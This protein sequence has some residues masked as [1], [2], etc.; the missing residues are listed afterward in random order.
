[1]TNENT[2]RMTEISRKGKGVNLPDL[3]MDN[4]FIER[5]WNSVKYEDIYLKAYDS[6]TEVKNGLASYYCT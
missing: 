2:A 3:K 6:M 5:F 1:M 4:V